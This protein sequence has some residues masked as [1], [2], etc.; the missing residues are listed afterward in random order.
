M[1][2]PNCNKTIIKTWKFCSFCGQNITQKNFIELLI[3]SLDRNNE[4]IKF[5][6]TF[7]Q[8]LW[9]PKVIINNYF[10]NKSQLYTKPLTFLL[11]SFTFVFLIHSIIGSL[12]YYGG[13]IIIDTSE[14]SVQFNFI[15]L[16]C[17]YSL[18]LYLIYIKRRNIVET[19]YF[20][21]FTFGLLKFTIMIVMFFFFLLLNKKNL[22]EKIDEYFSFS[23]IIIFP[24]LIRMNVIFYSI[25]TIKSKLFVALITSLLFVL[26]AYVNYEFIL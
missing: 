13:G 26:L 10:S 8:L 24:L 2:C 23:T 21:F 25:K 22:F 19:I 14:L 1:I 12:F 16:I 15:V 20:Q 7:W 11:L 18:I 6:R 4:I 17:I 9:K 3:G 5:F